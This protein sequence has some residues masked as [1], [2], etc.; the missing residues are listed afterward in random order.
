MHKVMNAASRKGVKPALTVVR[1]TKPLTRII[2]AF[3][4][5]NCRNAEGVAAGIDRKQAAVRSQQHRE[6]QTALADR[7]S[8]A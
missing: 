6:G 5:Q 4:I 2:G 8:V 3:L 7:H 1:R